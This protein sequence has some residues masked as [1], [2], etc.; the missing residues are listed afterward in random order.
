MAENKKQHFVPQS[1][2]KRFANTGNGKTIGVYSIKNSQYIPVAKLRTQAYKDYFY[3][4]DLQ[5]ERALSGVESRFAE[6]RNK[7]L[8]EELLPERYSK[9]HHVLIAF[10]FFLY[11]RTI[12]SADRVNE[13]ADHLVQSLVVKNFGEKRRGSVKTK[14][15]NAVLHSMKYFAKSMP[16]VYDLDFKLV[17]NESGEPFI[18]SDNPVVLYNQFLEPRRPTLNNIGLVSLGLQI[19]FPLTPESYLIFYDPAVYGVGDKKRRV[20]RVANASDV[21]AMNGLQ[22]MNSRNELFGNE[23]AGAHYFERLAATPALKR[24][25][26]VMHFDEYQHATDPLRTFVK[27]QE[28]EVKIGL[29]LSFVR[30]LRKAERLRLP[31]L[32]TLPR[33]PEVALLADYVEK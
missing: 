7:I 3:G 2:L 32:L 6:V 21:F 26:S 20:I 28:V 33:S 30:S 11:A 14:I 16:I 5:I 27:Y 29:K 13:I 24:R 25:D 8:A 19:F 22:Y 31:N 23:N 9:D 4:K 10:I 18:T 17:I 15:N 12:Y 1:Y